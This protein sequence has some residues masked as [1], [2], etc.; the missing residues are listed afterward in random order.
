MITGSHAPSA[1][2]A[3][4]PSR[5]SRWPCWK[6]KTSAPKLALMLIRL[7]STALIGRK[8]DP[9]VRNRTRAVTSITIAIAHGIEALK[10]AMKSAD[11]D[12]R[13]PVRTCAPSGDGYGPDLADQGATLV[14]V[15]QLG[16][17]DADLGGVLGDPVRRVRVQ[18]GAD[19]LRPLVRRDREQ[20]AVVGLRHAGRRVKDALDVGHAIAAQPTSST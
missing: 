18:C 19:L 2:E 6:M 4:K 9:K 3:L 20:R 5:L 10:L 1:P 11:R 16:G 14:R 17:E 12:G 13:P 15:G 7:I 8:T